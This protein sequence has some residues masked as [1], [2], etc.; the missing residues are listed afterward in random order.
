[1]SDAVKTVMT[2]MAQMMENKFN[3]RE[4]TFIAREAYLVEK[5]K[6]ISPTYSLAASR[7]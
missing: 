7:M 4:I 5:K 6:I 3:G 2:A 1:M